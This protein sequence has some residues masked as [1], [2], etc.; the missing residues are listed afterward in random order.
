MKKTILILLLLGLQ[1]CTKQIKNKIEINNYVDDR[2]NSLSERYTVNT[3]SKLKNFANKTTV[4]IVILIIDSI[5]DNN[6]NSF[7]NEISNQNGIG[8]KYANNGI[9][10]FLS[11]NDK[12]VRINIGSG[13]EWI[14]SDNL[15]GTIIKEMIP[16][17][18][19]GNY[20]KALDVALNKII[21]LTE[22]VSW[23]ISKKQLTQITKSDLSSIF[24][25]KGI[26][27]SKASTED[28]KYE[29][30]S[31]EFLIIKTNNGIK[32]NL[33]VTV[34][35]FPSYLI[36]EKEEKLI[37]ARLIDL[38]PLTFQLLDVE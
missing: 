19:V 13:M 31:N 21:P 20:E 29:N 14:I 32:L 36:E 30:Q 12:K 18:K 7:T 8:Q 17:L 24:Q 27:T 23:N 4:Q 38:N 2:T 25:F 11:K 28:I 16:F 26:K 1:F 37:T 3:S 9:L 5:G 22:S 6:I 35:Q 15:A 10:I 34:H 33:L